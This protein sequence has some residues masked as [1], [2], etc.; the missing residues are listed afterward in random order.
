MATTELSPIATAIDWLEQAARDWRLLNQLPAADRQRLHRAIAALSHAD[1]RANRKRRKAA[2]A[3]EVKRQEAMLNR[4][5][6]RLLRRRPLVTT[7]NVFPP[8]DEPRT[9][10]AERRTANAEP[11]TTNGERRTTNDRVCYVCKTP[12]SQLHHFYDQ[13]CPACADENFRARTEL[14][15]KLKQYLSA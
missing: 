11:G 14:R 5:G 7:P 9:V 10:N 4:T 15:E 1:P 13:L 8:N 3:D 12:Y 6:I 2:K